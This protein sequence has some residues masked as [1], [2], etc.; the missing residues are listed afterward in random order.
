MAT[1]A[2]QIKLRRDTAANWISSNPI[3]TEG[4]IGI[5]LD[6]LKMK[7][8]NGVFPWKYLPYI[9]ASTQTEFVI[10]N[11]TFNVDIS[12]VPG[13]I[14]LNLS[15]DFWSPTGDYVPNKYARLHLYQKTTGARSEIYVSSPIAPD[16]VPGGAYT[17]IT[18]TGS[19]NFILG[20]HYD[21]EIKRYDPATLQDY[22]KL[23]KLDDIIFTYPGA[24]ATTYSPLDTAQDAG[25]ACKIISAS[26]IFMN[27][28][29]VGP[30]VVGAIEVVD[31]TDTVVFSQ[32]MLLD[33]NYGAAVITDI[34][35]L[36]TDISGNPI[37]FNNGIYYI[38]VVYDTY[39][40]LSIQTPQFNFAAL[41]I[42][43]ID[44][45]DADNTLLTFTFANPRFGNI[46]GL[47]VIETASSVVTVSPNTVLDTTLDNSDID[48]TTNTYQSNILSQP[49]YTYY[50]TAIITFLDDTTVSYQT[51]YNRNAD[52]VSNVIN[53]DNTVTIGL[54]TVVD[55]GTFM[56]L[57]IE[58]NVE[59]SAAYISG[60]TIT[61]YSYSSI[62]TINGNLTSSTRYISTPSSPSETDP[63][64]VNLDS[65]DIV[66]GTDNYDTTPIPFLYNT[67]YLFGITYGGT[68]KFAALTSV[69][70]TATIDSFSYTDINHAL[71][72][73]SLT[74]SPIVGKVKVLITGPSSFQYVSA[75]SYTL[76]DG[77]NNIDI[78]DIT[79]DFVLTNTYTA[80]L[81]IEETYANVFLTS[82]SQTCTITNIRIVSFQ[83]KTDANIQLDWLAYSN[84]T[85]A[86]LDIYKTSDSSKIIGTQSITE[87]TADF[88]PGT[89]KILY[90]L[91][92]S[93]S[94]VTGATISGNNTV[95]A[96]SSTAGFIAGQYVSISSITGGAFTGYNG[97]GTI[98]SLIT[99]TSITVNIKSTSTTAPT[100]Y[101]SAILTHVFDYNSEYTAKVTYSGGRQSTSN[102]LPYIITGFSLPATNFNITNS[103]K[104]LLSASYTS[105]SN[106]VSFDFATE[107]INKLYQLNAAPSGAPTGGTLVSSLAAGKY[108]YCTV[109]SNNNVVIATTSKSVQYKPIVFTAD[110]FAF[111]YNTKD[112]K[113]P[114]VQLGFKVT[115]YKNDG[116]SK[117]VDITKSKINFKYSLYEGATRDNG[118]IAFYESSDVPVK[119]LITDIVYDNKLSKFKAFNLFNTYHP[120]ITSVFSYTVRGIITTET[121]VWT[122]ANQAYAYTSANSNMTIKFPDKENVT[123]T[124]INYV[125]NWKGYYGSAIVKIQRVDDSTVIGTNAIT[126]PYSPTTVYRKAGSDTYSLTGSVTTSQCVDTK[127][128]KAY[129]Q[130]PGAS[131][132]IGLTTANI[133]YHKSYISAINTL[134]CSISGGKATVGIQFTVT[135][136]KIFKIP[137]SVIKDGTALASSAI[138][139]VGDDKTHG[140]INSSTGFSGTVTKQITFMASIDPSLDITLTSPDGSTKTKSRGSAS[141]A[142][143]SPSVTFKDTSVQMG[144]AEVKFGIVAIS[145]ISI[146]CK[147]FSVLSGGTAIKTLSDVLTDHG[148]STTGSSVKTYNVDS[149]N[150]YIGRYYEFYINTWSGNDATKPTKPP[151]NNM[152]LINSTRL[153]YTPKGYDIIILSGQSNMAGQDDGFSYNKSGYNCPYEGVSGN[154]RTGSENTIKRYFPQYSA[155][156]ETSYDDSTFRLERTIPIID[157]NG[158]TVQFCNFNNADGSDPSN[159]QISTGNF[160]TINAYAPFASYVPTG[161]YEGV[162]LAY[163]FVKYYAT[164]SAIASNRRVFAIFTPWVG[165]GFDNNT[166]KN[167]NSSSGNA[168]TPGVLYNRTLNST[169]TV[170]E[171]PSYQQSTPQPLDYFPIYSSDHGGYGYDSRV[172]KNGRHFVSAGYASYDPTNPTTLSITSITVDYSSKV[173]SYATTSNSIIGS[174]NNFIISGCS[175]NTFNGIFTAISGTSA[176]VIKTYITT[177]GNT[178]PGAV[179]GT[180]A[181][182]GDWKELPSLLNQ[183]LTKNSGGLSAVKCKPPY[184]GGSITFQCTNAE[185]QLIADNFTTL[186]FGNELKTDYIHPKNFGDIAGDVPDDAGW[187]HGDTAGPSALTDSNSDDYKFVTSFLP[188]ILNGTQPFDFM[189]G[190]KFNDYTFDRI[191]PYLNFMQNNNIKFRGHCLFYNANVPK[192]FGDGDSATYGTILLNKK[193][194]LYAIMRHC[195]VVV[196]WISTN[197]PGLAVQY[198]VTNEH[199]SQ[200]NANGSTPGNTRSGIKYQT[201]GSTKSYYNDITYVYAALVGS[202]MADPDAQLFVAETSWGSNLK[203]VTDP[204]LA[205]TNFNVDDKSRILDG[206]GI[207]G[208]WN[209]NLAGTGDTAT[210][211]TGQTNAMRTYCTTNKIKMIYTEVD[212]CDNSNGNAIIDVDANNQYGV[213]AAFS[214]GTPTGYGPG[215]PGIKAYE[216]RQSA[217]FVAT[218]DVAKGMYDAG[219]GMPYIS[220]GGTGDDTSWLSNLNYGQYASP[221]FGLRNSR[222]T[223]FDRSFTSTYPSYDYST[224][225]TYPSGYTIPL[226]K[227]GNTLWYPAY[228]YYDTHASVLGTDKTRTKMKPAFTNLRNKLT[229]NLAT[230]TTEYTTN[231]LV[232]FVW[233]QGEN[234][235]T[236]P[237]K[238]WTGSVDE[239]VSAIANN[240]NYTTGGKTIQGYSS[241]QKFTLSLGHPLPYYQPYGGAFEYNIDAFTA[242]GGKYLVAPVSANGLE[243]IDRGH[244]FGEWVHFSARSE[245]LMGL[246]HFNSYLDKNTSITNT[247]ASSLQSTSITPSTVNFDPTSSTITFK[248]TSNSYASYHTTSTPILDP[249]GYFIGMTIGASSFYAVITEVLST[250]D[251]ADNHYNPIIPYTG[252]ADSGN[253]KTISIYTSS[254]ANYTVH[255]I[256]APYVYGTNSLK[257]LTPSMSSFIKPSIDS[258]TPGSTTNITIDFQ[259]ITLRSYVSTPTYQLNGTGV[260]PPITTIYLNTVSFTTPV[261]PTLPSK[262]QPTNWSLTPSYALADNTNGLVISRNIII[263]VGLVTQ[264]SILSVDRTSFTD[265][266]GTGGYSGTYEI[267]GTATAP[268]SPKLFF[269]SGTTLAWNPITPAGLLY[270]Y[271]TR[272][273]DFYFFASECRMNTRSSLTVAGVMKNNCNSDRRQ[274]AGISVAGSDFNPAGNPLTNYTGAGNDNF[275]FIYNTGSQFII[276]IKNVRPNKTY[277]ISYYFSVANG[278]VPYSDAAYANTHL[279]GGLSMY[280]SNSLPL[281]LYTYSPLIA[282]GGEKIVPAGWDTTIGQNIYF[283]SGTNSA[284]SNVSTVYLHPSGYTTGTPWN[285]SWKK[286]SFTFTTG[287]DAITNNTAY[288]QV[289]PLPTTRLSGSGY[290]G[291][292]FIDTSFN[293]AGFQLSVNN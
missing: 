230:A 51:Q 5:E 228:E 10:A 110:T 117:K 238:T 21:L 91:S 277:T 279:S 52:I 106:I 73:V 173:V 55:V 265:Y 205:N 123:G 83:N 287:T 4:E 267:I 90:T 176:T 124:K 263:N 102:S 234:N 65:I 250:L 161:G 108:Y 147:E 252:A 274:F 74:G 163:D 40:N 289:G 100:N 11:Y 214:V 226:G 56:P 223:I 199:R 268:G 149:S 85:T 185:I 212:V 261:Y 28:G 137:F 180:T 14:T 89:T 134:T 284:S 186:W 221:P 131:N 281:R 23:G 132:N 280:L 229:S 24:T 172:S 246:R 248:S 251:N 220:L 194:S 219:V 58:G 202:R 94:S 196:K 188:G 19:T 141:I 99:D 151:N 127:Q 278:Y 174:S 211:I 41:D 165:M 169:K 79:S 260:F 62:N 145:F 138:T 184:I 105:G 13:A 121:Q 46:T 236:L 7:A 210:S 20:Y 128:Y 84:G 181:I 96:V 33:A 175:N 9:A 129:V 116:T 39:N 70:G 231:R 109:T 177:Q 271:M 77:T 273:S 142:L 16:D 139:I 12:T 72:R 115:A 38:R 183:V 291:D 192:W 125:I 242:T 118:A 87:N 254:A 171:Y 233:Q 244:T 66:N 2:T 68:Y 101:G 247:D 182:K 204:I 178:A 97:T 37:P 113:H 164:S 259:P 143:V 179:S 216:S 286:L 18:L 29:W 269:Y 133:T 270:S 256:E 290:T 92:L 135:G 209:F 198:D 155:R 119:K 67:S 45:D 30:D 222:S 63:D 264:A 159:S 245:R 293:F 157:S 225:N 98:Q 150:F 111:S 57:Y 156:D 258:A 88:I 136:P 243:P 148:V 255:V 201:K 239:M 22:E 235:S 82:S 190:Y 253:T 36:R 130:F 213:S 103:G 237:G 168:N 144:I 71:L 191:V 47:Q 153:Q 75:Q 54:D 80:Y 32:P 34:T 266:T 122:L 17:A 158:N 104:P 60:R 64:I 160:T 241:N 272:N 215:I 112:A 120:Y 276:N 200:N 152:K 42:T 8:G 189:Y 197:Y 140:S 25:Y 93:N 78:P 275:F 95:Y 146:T 27:V 3:L 167:F 50:Y 43:N 76:V 15:D 257:T 285:G 86:T 292:E 44:F 187:S 240:I 114:Y 31:T 166:L 162:S 53:S 107:T 69:T 6:T 81:Y 207:Q 26:E 208:H 61:S 206:I 227:V 193:Q 170:V 232:S 59:S 154:V 35:I 49:I 203:M 195:Y 262:S 224:T 48:V 283:E 1:S 126:L 249:S 218:Y 288:L 282:T 217:L